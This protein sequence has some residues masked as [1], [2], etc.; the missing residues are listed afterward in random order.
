MFIPTTTA[1]V[2]TLGWDTLDIILVTGDAY[3]DSSYSGIA[4]IGHVLIDAGYRVGVIAQPDISGPGDIKRLGE[5]LLFWG[6]SSG[7]VDSMV[8]NYTASKKKRTQDDLTPGGVNTKRPD[9][10]LIAYTGLIRRFF[11]DTVPIVIGG[12]E[13][14]LRRLTHYDYWD[15]S[16]RRSVLIDAKADILVYG[17]GEKTVLELAT[18]FKNAMELS[19]IRGICYISNAEGIQGLNYINLP[20]FEKCVEDKKLF[21]ESFMALYSNC[22][23]MTARGLIQKHGE[24]YL[25]HNPPMDAVTTEEL[26][27]IYSLPYEGDAHP[28]YKEQ[29]E[30]RALD[31]IRFSI[32]THRGC[33][34]QC[35][36]C[37]IALHQGRAVI[38]RS[39][40]SVIEEAEK[41][42]KRKG[43]SGNIHDVGGPT[44][45]MYGMDCAKRKEKGSCKDRRCIF[46]SACKEMKIDHGRQINL[47]RRL[48]K[49]P[50]IKK[51][52][53]ASGVRYD[54]I[55]ADLKNGESYASELISEH[56]SGQMKVAPEHVCDNVLALMGKPSAKYL[57]RFRE[58][59]R[60]LN[61]EAGKKQFMTYYF[62]AAHPG[63]TD[64][65]MILLKRFVSEE[66]KLF[67][68]QVQIFTP[69]PSTISSLMYYIGIDPYNGK[70]IFVERDM[71]KK[72]RQKNILKK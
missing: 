51:V 15:E 31:T 19:D 5:P 67:P 49:L 13:A 10:A 55:F 34:G 1:E 2:K 29:G 33:F 59:F 21:Q 58:L 60:K 24:R 72:M 35:N 23:P 4:V 38:S 48:R 40:R 28:Y 18:G 8:S 6:V 57:R 39:E 62:I 22:D 68:E 12:M 50:G 61:K 52:F 65:D 7:S 46:P 32:T 64:E 63:C 11:K 54:L 17:M 16:L 20:S 42:I 25:V 41:F 27:H 56:I 71:N 3:I 53:I 37:A 70:E 45:N 66:L 30:I 44:A 36:F 26:D 14:S 43:F 47:L 9:R 69:T